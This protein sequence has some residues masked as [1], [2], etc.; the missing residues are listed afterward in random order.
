M[1]TV[2]Q[3]KDFQGFLFHSPT[4]SM[5]QS[6]VPAIGWTVISARRLLWGV[7]GHPKSKVRSDIDFAKKRYSDGFF[8]VSRIFRM[9]VM[10]MPDVR[11]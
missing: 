2:C 4:H 11:E 10:R 6:Q 1:T 7:Y 3:N 8:Q 5:L 9:L